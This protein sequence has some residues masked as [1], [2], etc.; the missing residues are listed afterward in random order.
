MAD[1]SIIADISYPKDQLS[2][3]EQ[4]TIIYIGISG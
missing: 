3:D 4:E 2:V 1:F